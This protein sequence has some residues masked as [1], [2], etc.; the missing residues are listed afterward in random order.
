MRKE[1][2]DMVLEKERLEVV[3]YAKKMSKCGLA[4]AS[5]GNVS[6]RNPETNLIAITP[7]N[8]DYD[9]LKL[10]DIVIVNLDGKVVHG[11]LKPS[12]ETPFHCYIYQK[13]KKYHGVLHTHSIYA[14]T[15]AVL[16]KELPV[17]ISNLVTAAGGA[18]PIADYVSGGSWELGKAIVEKLGDLAGVLL[19]NHGVVTVGP[20]LK[21]SFEAAAVIEDAAKIYLTAINAGKPTMLSPEE[22]ARIRKVKFEPRYNLDK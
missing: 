21:Q 9:M 10:E 6:A 19:Q 8:I 7:S 15:L 5:W 1:I 11:K 18:I 12:S 14:T 16:K 3:Y 20:S 2:T 17:V 22:I 13:K 4:P